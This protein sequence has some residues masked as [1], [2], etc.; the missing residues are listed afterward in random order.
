MEKL[1]ILQLKCRNVYNVT[2]YVLAYYNAL[3]VLQA[4]AVRWTTILST[5][6]DLRNN[7]TSQNQGN[8]LLLVTLFWSLQFWKKSST[9][10]DA[11]MLYIMLVVE[12]DCVRNIFVQNN[13][14][15]QFQ[16][17]LF[18]FQLARAVNFKRV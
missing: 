18:V 7:W 14:L 2:Y 1:I 16:I 4:A 11:Y 15:L 10:L 17:Q 6:Q 8:S 5:R 3:F 9:M 13:R 12:F